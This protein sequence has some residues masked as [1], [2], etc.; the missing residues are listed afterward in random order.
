MCKYMFSS[1][2]STEIEF[3][4]AIFYTIH[5][6]CGIYL[7]FQHI[8]IYIQ[9]ILRAGT[10]TLKPIISPSVHLVFS[11]RGFLHT[12]LYQLT[13]IALP[14]KYKA[15]RINFFFSCLH[16]HLNTILSSEKIKVY[17]AH[18]L[19]SHVCYVQVN[20]CKESLLF[21]RRT[22]EIQLFQNSKQERIQKQQQQQ[23]KLNCQLYQKNAS[24]CF[25]W[26]INLPLHLA[27]A[28][29]ILLAK[30]RFCF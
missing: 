30:I 9:K 25:A 12:K 10:N 21:L 8:P 16:G 14:S 1:G 27:Y 11:P 5:R 24:S 23:Q 3:S 7:H 26:S 4:R 22:K 2:Q 18:R 19:W 6:L 17:M 20:G 15:Q 29:K 28:K 13:L